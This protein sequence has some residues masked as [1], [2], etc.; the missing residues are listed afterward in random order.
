[1][2]WL[3]GLSALAAL[4]VMLVG[5]P[6]ALV[7][8]GRAPEG[9]PAA[10]ARP[11]DGTVLLVGLTAVGW[12]AWSAFTASIVV[13][14]VRL[15]TAGRL[16][17]R[18]PLLGGLQQ[19]STALLLAVLALAPARSADVTPD[20]ARVVAL[21]PAPPGLA[22]EPEARVEL[23]EPGR[24]TYL[25]APGDDLWTVSERLLGDG[26]RWREL[27]AANPVELGDPSR[28]LTPGSRLALPA[29]RGK[30][31]LRVRVVPGDTLSGLALEHLGAAGRWPSIAAANDDLI[32]DPDHIEVGWSLVVPGAG[33]APRSSRP[34]PDRPEAEPTL[35]TEPEPPPETPRSI[36]RRP[37]NPDAPPRPP[38]PRHR[39]PP[40]GLLRS[41][42]PPS[43][44]CSGP[45]GRW[46]PPPSSG[47]S[48]PGVSCGS[49]S[50]RWAGG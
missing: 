44:R 38:R 9:W 23:A 18:I 45:S 39:P 30:E 20:Q 37:P 1:M 10:L 31:P 47:R 32:R 34:D 5:A 25:V 49:A 50:V 35:A 13:E 4:V 22:A 7:A 41:R 19:V 17:F 2:R 15:L 33:K 27:A 28:P 43:L 16:R 21:E 29:G 42:R 12:L 48:R 46:L 6:L 40:R 24:G 26:G 3:R 8:W 14:A 36:S 11:D